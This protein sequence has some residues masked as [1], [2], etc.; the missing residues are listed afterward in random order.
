MRNRLQGKVIKVI[1][2]SL[3]IVLFTI[4][5][6]VAILN[7]LHITAEA[8][9]VLLSYSSLPEME[10][11]APIFP[12]PPPPPRESGEAL[13]TP[14]NIRSILHIVFSERGEIISDNLSSDWSEDVS[15]Q[16]L[17]NARRV[18][19]DRDE[20]GYMSFFRYLRVKED[21]GIVN[22]YLLDTQESFS[23]YFFFLLYM[24][25]SAILGILAVL[26]LASMFS[27]RLIKPI[28]EG[29]EKQRRFITDAGHELKTPLT[30][31]DADCELIEMEKGRSEWASDIKKQVSRLTSLTNDLIFLSKME[32][33]GKENMIELPFS[34]IVRDALSSFQILARA[35]GK[36]I[37]ADIDDIVSIYGDGKQLEKLVYVL[38][39][40]AVKYSRENTR[41]YIRLKSKGKYCL[42][43]TRNKTEDANLRRLDMLFERFY[44]ADESR[45]SERKGFGIGLAI[46]KAVVE[47]H[48]GK[49]AAKEVEKGEMTIEVLL[50]LRKGGI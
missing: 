40:N 31:I 24:I 2:L 5:L 14:F 30:I 32:E 50:P 44:R 28:V 36:E 48:K 21:G 29:Y 3:F 25:L 10:E 11:K 7:Y 13:F 33:G 45:N 49:I 20:K 9:D 18:F 22:V 37:D 47:S 15:R 43:E 17:L 23:N 39:D 38:L 16:V 1:S 34:E 12:P 42:L 41:I 35:E 26:V 19:H 46:A 27:L 4:I 8:D 6:I